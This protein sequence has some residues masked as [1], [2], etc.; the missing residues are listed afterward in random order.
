MKHYEISVPV[1][2]GTDSIRLASICCLHIGHKCHN[3]EK[4]LWYRDYILNTPNVYAFDLGDDIENALPGDSE[5]DSMMWDSDMSPEK[6]YET[7]AEFWAP[8]V[9]KGKLLLT[10][11][12]NHFWRS[13]AK[14]GIS[15]GKNLN[16]FLK[17]IAKEEKTQEPKWGRWMAMSKL[18]V[19]DQSYLIHS[20]HGAGGGTKSA[21]ALNKC[22]EQAKSHIAD[23]YLMGHYHKRVLAD[24]GY[25][26][27]NNKNG[28]PEFKTRFFACTGSFLEW[29][30]SYAERMG[31][32]P[33][34]TGIVEVEL[35][36]KER[37]IRL[38][39]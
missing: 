24:E 19:G 1:S 33:S 34:V 36:A 26:T 37:S 10:H 17:G 8:V 21:S 31:L 6:Q 25:T 30:G 27:W 39:M 16:I 2:K 20:W 35:G 11:D 5:H 32:G 38:I 15:I 13:E 23:V 28:A 7:A 4:A 22:M 3:K 18:T 9:K 14:T 29:S 12:S